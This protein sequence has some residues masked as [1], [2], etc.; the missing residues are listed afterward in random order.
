VKTLPSLLSRAG[1]GCGT[2]GRASLLRLGFARVV[3][4]FAINLAE[5]LILRKVIPVVH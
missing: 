2:V 3:R 5:Y 1:V 4:L